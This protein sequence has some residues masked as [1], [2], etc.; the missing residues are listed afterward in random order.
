MSLAKN[1]G[2][3]EGMGLEKNLKGGGLKISQISLR[4]CE[5]L[6]SWSKNRK[7]ISKLANFGGGR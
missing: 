3:G 1:P 5:N 4:T 6:E 2:G 7:T